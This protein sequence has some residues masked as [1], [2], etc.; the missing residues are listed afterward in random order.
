MIPDNICTNDY[1]LYF[2]YLHKNLF[3]YLHKFRYEED[4]LIKNPSMLLCRNS[5]RRMFYAK[6]SLSPLIF[7]SPPGRFPYLNWSVFL[8]FV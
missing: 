6:T 1:S 8:C 4:L 7:N 5:R 3:T 2:T